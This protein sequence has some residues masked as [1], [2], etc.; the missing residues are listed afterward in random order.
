MAYKTDKLNLLAQPMAGQRTW[1]YSDTGSPGL[2][3]AAAGFFSDGIAKG[4]KVGDV[5]LASTPTTSTRL[6]V[7]A[8]QAQDTGVQF[9]T[10][11]AGDTG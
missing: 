7:T 9:A 6:V 1:M 4:M 2:A 8:L 11:D 5:V 3:P 10:A